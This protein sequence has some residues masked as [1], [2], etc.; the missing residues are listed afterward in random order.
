MTNLYKR[1]QRLLP[2]PPLRVGT[3]VAY[4]NGVAE[5]EESGGGRTLARGEASI[6]DRV[7]FRDGVIEGPAPSLSVEV[8]EV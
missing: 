7:F 4:A 5:I 3:V 1:F 2:N 6:N 8:I